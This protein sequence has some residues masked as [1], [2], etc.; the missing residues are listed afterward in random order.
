M[1][2]HLS[3]ILLGGRGVEVRGDADLQRLGVV[4]SGLAGGAVDVDGA[5]SVREGAAD[6]GEDHRE[7]EVPRAGGAGWGAADADPDRQRFLEG[8]RGD[9]G[10]DEWRAVAAGPGDPV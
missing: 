6:V 2:E 3:G 4:A 5:A 9:L 8:A 10:V 1:L 7:A